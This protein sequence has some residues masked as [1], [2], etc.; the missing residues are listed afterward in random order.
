VNAKYTDQRL[1]ITL[2]H[3]LRAGVIFSATVVLTGGV[4]YLVRHGSVRPEYGV[5]RGEPE[6][7][8]DISGLLRGVF[9]GSGRAI[10]QL[11][12]LCLIAT[13]V[14]R[15]VFSVYA[16]VRERDYLYVAVTLTVLSLL[17]YSILGH[18]F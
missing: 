6:S 14:A 7:Y 13:P 1:D 17:L 4:V 5:F 11:G 2:G 3:L 9:N 18:H 10:I 12:L 16:F 8:R 15:V